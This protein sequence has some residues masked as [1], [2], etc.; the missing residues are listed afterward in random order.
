MQSNGA[1]IAI[2]RK[3]A[4]PEFLRRADANAVLFSGTNDHKGFHR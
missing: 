4:M 2:N 1:C 3:D